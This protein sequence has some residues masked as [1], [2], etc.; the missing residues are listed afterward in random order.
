MFA[1]MLWELHGFENTVIYLQIAPQKQ[2]SSALICRKMTQRLVRKVSCGQ[3]GTEPEKGC[4]REKAKNRLH[5]TFNY[6]T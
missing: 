4:R 2:I 6:G 3:K 5:A 1:K